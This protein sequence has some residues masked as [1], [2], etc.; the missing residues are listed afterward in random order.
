MAVGLPPPELHLCPESAVAA[1]SHTTWQGPPR[2][3]GAGLYNLGNTCFLNATLQCLAYCPPLAQLLDDSD[4]NDDD[5]VDRSRGEPDGGASARAA[6]WGEGGGGQTFNVVMLLRELFG[7]LHGNGNSNSSSGGKKPAEKAVS[8]KALV[9][10]LRALGRQFRVGR[11]E[12]AHEFLC[13]LLDGLHKHCL[14]SQGLRPH[15]PSLLA[16]RVGD[17]SLVHRLFGGHLRSRLMCST[18]RETSDK[19]EPFLD[20]SLHVKASGA[21]AAA[22]TGGGGGHKAKANGNGSHG[23]SNS[24]KAD[25]IEAALERYTRGEVLEGDNQWECPRCR[26]RRNATKSLAIF[27]APKVLCLQL[28][29]FSFGRASAG[30]KIFAPVAFPEQL[31]LPIAELDPQND[32]NGSGNSAA[33]AASTTTTTAKNDAAAKAAAA[34]C[35]EN[36]VSQERLKKNG[37]S[38]A[39]PTSIVGYTLTGV[40]VHRGE[41]VHSG[42]Y[43]AFAK[44]TLFF[45]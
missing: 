16:S 15:D 34:K 18:C 39:G 37:G 30:R 9:A 41:S 6:L 2:G 14:R 23:H 21:P 13:H 11:Q 38:G 17:T 33:A 29:R 27:R 36:S 22:A 12:D 26:T 42:H 8:P 25:T 31:N 28:K 3:V 4:D 1:L 19:F 35:R 5:G 45:S 32:D 7:R 10:S 43:Y 40:L 20:L 44:V 24:G